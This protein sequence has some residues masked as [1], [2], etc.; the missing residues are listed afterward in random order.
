MRR[1]AAPAA[2]LSTSRGRS[3]RT[4]LR[5]CRRIASVSQDA[6]YRR[7]S[8]DTRGARTVRVTARG[9]RLRIQG[10]ADPK[11]TQ[12]VRHMFRLDEDL[13]RFY[14]LVREDDLAWCALGAGMHAALA[15]GV[16]RR[17]QDDLDVGTN[18]ARLAVMEGTDLDPLQHVHVVGL[19]LVQLWYRLRRG[20]EAPAAVEAN[21]VE[22]R[23]RRDH[24]RCVSLLAGQAFE[25]LAEVPAN[26]LIPVLAADVQKCEL[27]ESRTDVRSDNSDT[28]ELPLCESSQC[29]SAFSEMALALRTLVGDGVLALSFGEPCRRT[30]IPLPQFEPGAVLEEDSVDRFSSIDL[31][32]ARQVCR[33]EPP[34]CNPSHRG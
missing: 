22:G 11:L 29:D 28:D 1:F 34:V 23:G 33:D 2:S 24:H 26:A 20:F 16:R 4:Q 25:L 27:R 5:S 17:G 7:S 6:R 31:A 3:S 10:S 9:K 12:T 15:N 8:S 14:E 18:Q 13:S 32:D 21:G 30:E 19:E